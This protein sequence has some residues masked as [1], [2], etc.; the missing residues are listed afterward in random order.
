MSLLIPARKPPIWEVVVHLQKWIAKILFF[1]LIILILFSA[2]G[3]KE[4][5]QLVNNSY[6]PIISG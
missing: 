4:T 6:L 5:A 2:F 3:D 1:I